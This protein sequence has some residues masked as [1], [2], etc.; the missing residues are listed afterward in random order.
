ME[1]TFR[2]DRAADVIRAVAEN[3]PEL[4]VGAGTVLTV[5]QVD[6]ALDAGARFVVSPVLDEHVVHRCREAGVPVI[7]GVATA[8]ELS[9]AIGL[10]VDVVKFFP[11]ESLGGVT[12]IRAL[13]SVMPGVA[14]MPT[15]GIGEG[16]LAPYLTERS[17]IACG[18]TWLLP[19]KTLADRDFDDIERRVDR[20]VEIVRSVRSDG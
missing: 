6:A 2:T 5:S 12:A 16:T 19:R 11:A 1:V 4:L 20:A 8:T 15:G 14:F 9:R 10:G 18:G 3:V 13:A 17:V 7:P